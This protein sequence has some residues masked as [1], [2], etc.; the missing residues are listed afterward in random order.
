MIVIFLLFV[1]QKI[2][3]FILEEENSW[4]GIDLHLDVVIEIHI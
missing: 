1:E 2:L 3:I 4:I